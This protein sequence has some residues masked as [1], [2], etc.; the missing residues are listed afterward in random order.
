MNTGPIQSVYMS[1]IRQSE[2]RVSQMNCLISYRP[3]TPNDYG[4]CACT[5]FMAEAISV[6]TSVILL[7]TTRVVL[8]LAATRE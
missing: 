4:R 5:I 1:Q 8:A 3:A 6:E 2:W 7:G